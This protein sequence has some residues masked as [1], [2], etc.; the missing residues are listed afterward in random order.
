MVKKGELEQL[1]EK[2]QKL[3]IKLKVEGL[4]HSSIASKLNEEFS[5][6]LTEQQ[7]NGFINRNRSKTFQI[8]KEEKDF[9]FKLA[10][11]HFDTL[12]QLKYL[13]KE[14][15]EFFL[16]VKKDP[17]LSSKQIF[18]PKCNHKFRIQMKSFTSLIRTADHLLKEIEHQD[19]VLGRMK[20]KGM[21]INYNFVDLSKKIQNV[22]PQL[23]HQAER[24]GDIKI[25]K[26]KKYKEYN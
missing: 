24:Q 22:M 20:D 5:A 6:D 4:S 25:I 26:K 9:D 8:L 7:V 12:E 15:W 10:K 1:G 3:A 17:E 13:N 23:M 21:T 2:A 16:S 19:K 11:W 18:C 14:M